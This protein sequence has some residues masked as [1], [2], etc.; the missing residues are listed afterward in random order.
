MDSFGS[1]FLFFHSSAL[2]H[3]PQSDDDEG[4]AQELTHIEEHAV[5]EGNLIFLGVLDEDAGS[6]DEREA[7]AEEESRADALG[8]VAIEPPVDDEE[9]GVAQG[10]VELAGMAWQLVYALEDEGPGHIRRAS[11]DFG[12]HQVA[13]AYGAGTDGGDDGDV[14]EHRPQLEARAADVEYEADDEAQRAAVAGQSLES[15]VV[16]VAHGVLLHGQHHLH[17]MAQEVLGLVEQAVAQAGTDEYAEEAVEDQG[18]ELLLGDA[19][20]AEQPVLQQIHRE[21]ADGPAQR[22]P[23]HAERADVEQEDVGVPVD[24]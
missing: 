15:R 11:D 12:V 5:L 9:Q 14:V 18:V 2:P 16:P 3:A 17:G 19:L 13:H 1:L 4:D 23:T 10:L 24:E 8:I 22:V 21:E 7:E 6:E 20:L